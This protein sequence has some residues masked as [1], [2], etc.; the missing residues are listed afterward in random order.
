MDNVDLSRVNGLSPELVGQVGLFAIASTVFEV[1]AFG[2]YQGIKKGYRAII[3][4][5]FKQW[6]Q[7]PEFGVDIFD[8]SQLE[9]VSIQVIL[10]EPLYDAKKQLKS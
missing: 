2:E 4:R 5:D 7:I 6:D 8:L 1:K 10:F 9:Q 3:Q